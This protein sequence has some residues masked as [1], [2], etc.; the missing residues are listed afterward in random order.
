ME[1]INEDILLQYI[2]GTLPA[3]G[4]TAVEEWLAASPENAQLLEQLY[5]THEVVKR[6]KVMRSV[7]PD[8]ALRRFKTQVRTVNKKARLHRVVSILQRTAAI[9]F[10]PLLLSLGYTLPQQLLKKT[11]FLQDVQLSL[12]GRNLFFFHKSAPF[13]PDAVLST[14]NDNQGIDVFG[15]PTTRSLGF[16]VK[17]SF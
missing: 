9:L 8:Q 11:K 1:T 3:S 15:M 14:K 16:N 4:V 17:L 7:D 2:D 12:V 6:I 10:L 13:D 5:F